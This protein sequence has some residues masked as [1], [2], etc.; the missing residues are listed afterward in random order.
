M[1]KK[2]LYFSILVVGILIFGFVSFSEAT[3]YT[4]Y[5]TDDTYYHQQEPA[6]NFGSDSSL[7]VGDINGH[8]G[9]EGVYEFYR[10]FLLFDLSALSLLP[11]ENITS[12][13]LNL[14]Q[15]GIRGADDVVVHQI[16]SSWNEN[17]VTYLSSPTYNTDELS[18]LYLAETF[19]WKT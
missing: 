3:V 16:T 19:S 5:P 8:P 10:S 18:S 4:F 15:T 12:A 13:S 14:Y 2:N 11:G 9:F 7:K 1:K 6:A 17:S